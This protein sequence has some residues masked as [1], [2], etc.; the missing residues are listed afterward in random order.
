MTELASESPD[1]PEELTSDNDPRSY[2]DLPRHEHEV[3][4]ARAA[5]EPQLAECCQVGLVVAVDGLERPSHQVRDLF[6]DGHALPAQQV[7]G[8]MEH[9]V[10]VDQAGHADPE[11][12]HGEPGAVGLVAELRGDP[13]SPFQHDVGT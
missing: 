5:G 6:G 13:G 1:S 8:A 12:R 2:A 11:P 7:G 10:E 4:K 3:K 9:S